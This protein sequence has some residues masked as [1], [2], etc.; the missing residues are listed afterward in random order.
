[1]TGFLLVNRNIKEVIQ[2]ADA[3]KQKDTLRIKGTTWIASA[4]K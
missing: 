1:M 3:L 2:T 4:I